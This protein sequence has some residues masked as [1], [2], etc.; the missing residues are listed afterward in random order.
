M[1]IN[2]EIYN[3]ISCINIVTVAEPIDCHISRCHGIKH[4]GLKISQVGIG[5]EVVFDHVYTIHDFGGSA[6]FV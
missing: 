6:H 1:C 3:V 2:H 4:E 5:E